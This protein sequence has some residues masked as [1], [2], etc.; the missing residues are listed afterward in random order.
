MC[1]IESLGSDSNKVDS[2]RFD[3]VDSDVVSEG[4]HQIKVRSDR[5][6]QVSLDEQAQ[7]N[8]VHLINLVGEGGGGGGG[9]LGGGGD[10]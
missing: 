10:E 5:Q 1:Y 7:T 8:Q 4:V 9:G 6:P 2:I 3:K